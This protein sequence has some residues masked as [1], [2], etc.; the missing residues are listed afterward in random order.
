MEMIRM[1]SG[2]VMNRIPLAVEKIEILIL[3]STRMISKMVIYIMIV[4]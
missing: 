4:I 1:N 2:L 3:L